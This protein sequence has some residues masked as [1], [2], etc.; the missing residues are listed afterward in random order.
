MFPV[1]ICVRNED[2]LTARMTLHAGMA[3]SRGFE[4]STF[5]YAFTSAGILFRVD[6]SVESQAETF[7][8]EFGGR[9]IRELADV[10]PQAAAD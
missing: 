10:R 1:E 5:R 7:A 2:A 6:F 9:V 3:R 4:P 8:N